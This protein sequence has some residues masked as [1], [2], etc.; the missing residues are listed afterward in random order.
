MEEEL[1]AGLREEGGVS[2]TNTLHEV[3]P[4]RVYKACFLLPGAHKRDIS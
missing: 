1:S 3:K 2:S 4:Q